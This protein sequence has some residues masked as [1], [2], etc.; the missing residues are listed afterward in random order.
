[1]RLSII[2]ALSSILL[3]AACSQEDSATS[4]YA[5]GVVTDPDHYSIEFEND[6]VRVMRVKYAPGDVSSMHSHNPLL[7][8]SLSLIHI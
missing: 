5:N 3:L 8:V 6:Y 2:G 7:A 4:G 1:M